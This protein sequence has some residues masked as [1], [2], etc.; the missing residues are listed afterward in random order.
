MNIKAK[1]VIYYSIPPFC[2]IVALLST[3][4][5]CTIIQYFTANAVIVNSIMIPVG[6][7]TGWFSVDWYRAWRKSLLTKWG[8]TAEW[9]M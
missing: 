9:D 7:A 2:L 5:G 3:Y 4:I 1:R 6:I 8:L